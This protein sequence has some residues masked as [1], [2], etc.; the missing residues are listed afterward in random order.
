MSAA[1][2]EPRDATLHG[3]LLLAA[4]TALLAAHSLHRLHALYLVPARAPLLGVLAAGAGTVVGA[5]AARRLVPSS[6]RAVPWLLLG[7]AL[8]VGASSVVPFVAFDRGPWAARAAAAC[9]CTTAAA[10]TAAVLVVGRTVGRDAVALGFVA[11]VL[12]PGR[13]GAAILYVLVVELALARSGFLRSGP[14]L[15]AVL[16]ALGAAY[17]VVHRGLHQGPLPGTRA[18]IAAAFAVL[19]AVVAALVGIERLVPSRELARFPD[20]IVFATRESS[21][22]YTVVASPGG[23]E[24][25]CDEQ[26][27]VS[28]LDEQRRTAALVN[29]ALSSAPRAGRVLLL[30]GGLG[31]VERDVL[32][33]PRVESLT[34]VSPDAARRRLV[35]GLP[36]LTERARGS[37][38][39]PRVRLVV[40][41][42]LVFLGRDRSE[43]YDVIIADLPWPLGYREGKLYTHHAFARLAGRLSASGVLVVP[44][45]SA[46]TAR[47]ALADVVATVESVGLTTATYHV[48]V[49]TIGVASFVVCFR[50]GARADGLHAALGGTDFGTDLH[51]GGPGQVA[52]LHAQSVVA[53]FDAARERR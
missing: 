26:L 32:A 24:L 48:A 13:L 43:P 15:A 53:A 17:A 25:F 16:A 28:S 9:I 36:F 38:D 44:G 33:D 35:Q 7:A 46:L 27:A 21:T 41:E 6:Y 14:A 50:D 39:S 42:P 4:A 29:P 19:A 47:Q 2:D 8:A 49:P 37:L 34:V 30:Q 20:E 18:A 5:L 52:T 10:L 45:G 31:M 1:E 23:Y 11:F 12:R 22:D 40:A 3:W 51:P